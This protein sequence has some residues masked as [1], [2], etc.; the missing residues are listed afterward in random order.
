[1]IFRSSGAFLS[2]VVRI[3]SEQV[4]DCRIWV[5]VF[6]EWSGCMSRSVQYEFSRCFAEMCA[7]MSRKMINLRRK[8]YGD[9]VIDV[10]A[11]R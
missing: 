4:G 10:E 8:V 11:S 5:G 1:V 3:C 2:Y 9:S 7:E 6:S